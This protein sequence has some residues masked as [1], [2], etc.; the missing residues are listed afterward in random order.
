MR[1]FKVTVNGISYD[2]SVEEMTGAGV[3]IQPTAPAPVV[4]APKAAEP[5]KTE[6]AAVSASAFQLTAPMPGT[7]ADIKVAVGDTV[8]KDQVGIILEAMKMEN[9]IFIPIAGKVTSVNVTK[10]AAVKSG[11]VLLTIE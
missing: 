5:K 8:A 3:P 6:A 7:I 9:E 2:V 1:N 10:G 11:D 4:Q